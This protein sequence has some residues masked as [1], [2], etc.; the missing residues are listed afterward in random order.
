MKIGVERQVVDI[1]FLRLIKDEFDLISCQIYFAVVDQPSPLGFLEQA[2]L[3]SSVL[4]KDL[5]QDLF[6]LSH[7][8]DG[9]LFI[10]LGWQFS[11]ARSK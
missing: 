9:L 6:G 11:I 1:W 5:Q 7:F 4:F 10:R 2:R 3:L 8:F